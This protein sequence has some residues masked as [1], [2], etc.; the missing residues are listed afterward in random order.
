MQT[1]YLKAAD[2]ETFEQ[3]MID[4]NLFEDQI[5]D[6]DTTKRV[7]KY[8]SDDFEFDVIGKIYTKT[9]NVIE[10]N[11]DGTDETFDVEEEVLVD[12]Y[13]VNVLIKTGPRDDGEITSINDLLPEPLRQLIIDAPATPNRTFFGI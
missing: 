4:S 13:H 8:F 12:G 11:V 9:G 6:E 7:L 1:I 2:K 10:Q 3:C 5:V